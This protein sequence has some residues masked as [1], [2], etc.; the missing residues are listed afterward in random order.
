MDQYRYILVCSASL[1][2]SK[3]HVM[4][5]FLES[6]PGCETWTIKAVLLASLAS[7]GGIIGGRVF[8]FSGVAYPR[9]FAPKRFWLLYYHFYFGGH[10]YLGRVFLACIFLMYFLL[11]NIIDE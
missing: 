2:D 3:H 1:E 4:T 11:F 5:N 7:L 10:T 8:D 6:C 9:F